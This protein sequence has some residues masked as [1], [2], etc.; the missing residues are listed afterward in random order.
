MPKFSLGTR[1]FFS[2]LFVM[3]V[4][5][6]SFVAMAKLSSPKMFVLRL[7]QLERQ[8]FYTVRSART[9]LIR[10]F[11]TAW[12]SSAILACVVGGTT[13]GFLSYF[14][15]RQTMKQFKAMQDITQEFA[16]GNLHQRMASSDIPEF[17]QLASSF[18]YMAKSLE[19]VEKK[20]R[21]LIGDLTHE[22]RTPLTV[23]RGYLEELADG[24]IEANPELY[25]RLVQETRRLERLTYDLQELSKSEA[26]YL[27]INLQS[28]DLKPILNSLVEKFADQLLEDGPVLQLDCPADL[29][30]VL[31]DIDRTEQVLVNL[32]GNALRY[33]EKGTITL[34]AWR[35][36]QKVW[37]AVIDTGIGIAQEDL[38]YVFEKFWRADRSRSRYSGGSGLGL[39]IARRLV[40][41]QNGH[42]TVESAL[43]K[44]STFKFSLPVSET[45]ILNL[46]S[47]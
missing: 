17:N 26:G 14:A 46:L 15:S 27:S 31:A 5:L 13:A 9:Y 10:G 32:L 38:P 1:F 36:K 45:N 21:E 47:T 3:L 42:L 44:G 28:I 7:E 30:M 23:V 34:K 2:H 19:D 4:G 39:S 41:L 18:N 29:P 37:I 6:I 40:E 20:R 24:S 8:G 12:D 33:T 43:G 25:W 35:E 11:E 22:L 16:A